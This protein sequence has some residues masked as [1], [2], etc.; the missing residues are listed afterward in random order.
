MMY[1]LLFRVT[2]SIDKKGSA[3]TVYQVIMAGVAPGVVT[4]MQYMV[5]AMLTG[6]TTGI[7]LYRPLERLEIFVRY[8]A[9][10]VTI[11]HQTMTPK[12]L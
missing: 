5:T 11:P 6:Q 3:R 10:I 4:I 8:H 2:R 7:A 1:C 12:Q 9:I